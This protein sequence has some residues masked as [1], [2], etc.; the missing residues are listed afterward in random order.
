MLAAN[1]NQP[2][3]YGPWLPTGAMARELGAK[4]YFTGKPCLRGHIA[5]RAISSNNCMACLYENGV[6]LRKSPETADAKREY[7]AQYN[8]I[9]RAAD[10]AFA[11]RLREHGR[12]SD[13]RPERRAKKNEDKKRRLDANPELRARVN[14]QHKVSGKRWKKANKEKVAIDG[15]LRRARSLGADGDH[16]AEDLALILVLQENLCA[17]CLVDMTAPTVDHIVPLIDNGTHWP[18]NIQMMC[19]PCNSGKCGYENQFAIDRR[20]LA[21]GIVTPPGFVEFADRP[22]PEKWADLPRKWP[23]NDNEEQESK[24]AA[25]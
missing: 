4:T 24:D 13:V 19:L 22:L 9:R 5:P 6:K 23:A 1:D 21:L 16:T 2:V 8:R 20:R 17:C 14:L 18:S 11:E 12:K 3:R 10:P 7:H 15:R 25:A